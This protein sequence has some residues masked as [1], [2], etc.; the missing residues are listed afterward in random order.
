MH[1]MTYVQ[2]AEVPD[3]AAEIRWREWKAR[4]VAR[5]R[6]TDTIMGRL[7]IPIAIALAAW[8]T[9]QIVWL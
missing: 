1:D 7:T 4:S 6:R 9:V 8:L 5:D 2:V 3:A